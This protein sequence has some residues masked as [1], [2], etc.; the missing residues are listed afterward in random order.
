MAAYRNA[1]SRQARVSASPACTVSSTLPTAKIAGTT[2]PVLP[3]LLH[4]RLRDD[5]TCL[6]L[7]PP[8]LFPPV[9]ALFDAIR[10]A[11]HM[12]IGCH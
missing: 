7:I 8:V 1:E 5:A 2:E 12:R 3:G 9:A 10:E 6:V 11:K 4:D